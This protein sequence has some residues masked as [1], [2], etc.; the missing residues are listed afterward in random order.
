MTRFHTVGVVA[1][2]E[3]DCGEVFAGIRDW[4]AEHD[5]RIV[6]LEGPSPLSA[7]GERLPDDQFSTSADFMIAAGGDG[8]ILR[9]LALAAPAG[10]PVLAVNVGHLGFLAE[11]EPGELPRALAAISSGAS[12][13]RSASHSAAG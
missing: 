13:S 6:T 7:V 5:V 3:R 12:T 10:Q 11:I 2:P 1:H 9:A 8:T 4:A